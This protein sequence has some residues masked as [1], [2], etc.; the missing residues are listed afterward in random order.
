MAP[1]LWSVGRELYQEQTGHV[2]LRLEVFLVLKQ[3][4]RFHHPCKKKEGKK[5]ARKT[6][7]NGDHDENEVKR[8]DFGANA[9]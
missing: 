6:C 8:K 3:V 1:R 5:S 4:S 2:R 7:K 9:L